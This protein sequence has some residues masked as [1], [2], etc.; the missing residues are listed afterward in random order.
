[1]RDECHHR[2]ALVVAPG[3]SQTHLAPTRSRP[4]AAEVLRPHPKMSALDTTRQGFPAPGS[5]APNYDFEMAAS[6]AQQMIALAEYF[7]EE[8]TSEQVEF[9]RRTVG[10]GML[11]PHWK[12]MRARTTARDGSGSSV[13]RIPPAGGPGQ[14]RKEVGPLRTGG[15]A[16]AP[17]GVPPPIPTG[18]ASSSPMDAPLHL[19]TAIQKLKNAH[20]RNRATATQS[21]PSS[22][23]S[24]TS[25]CACRGAKMRGTDGTPG[26]SASRN[27]TR[28]PNGLRGRWCRRRWQRGVRRGQTRT[29]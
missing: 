17:A 21:R 26:S 27:C 20:E 2:S 5:G 7:N 16:S 14:A 8:L 18:L 9:I 24:G 13:E 28:R 4:R 15:S 11:I 12:T 3:L 6:R 22:A 29:I 10:P 1:M 19:E 25:S 23:S